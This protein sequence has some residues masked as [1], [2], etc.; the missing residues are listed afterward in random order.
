MTDQ[1]LTGKVAIVTGGAQGIGGDTARRLARDGAQVLIVDVDGDTAAAN[2][3]SIEKAGGQAACMVGDVAQEDIAKRMVERV[4]ELY[5]RLD[6]LVQNAYGGAGGHGSAVEI[7]PEQWRAGMGQLVDALYLGARAAVPAMEASGAPAGMAASEVG[8]IVN[9]S[10]AHGLLQAPRFLV[11][12]VGKTAV[13]GLTKQLA[14]DFGPSGITV[15]AIAPGH[16]LTENMQRSWEAHGDATGHGKRLFELQYPVRRL[17][18][19][20]DVAHAVAFLCTPGAS[21][22]TGV[23]LPVDGGHTTQLQENV[24]MDLKD[25]IV[26]HPD[27][28]THFDRPDSGTPRG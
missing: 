3:E 7:E 24:V 14:V 11:Y 1:T 15:N 16:I 8:R 27:L 13:I 9:I 5:G 2:I 17:G 23:V 21:F 18:Q 26:A 6:I 19:P 10:S 25:Y 4:V 22:I 28:R 20:E 12:E